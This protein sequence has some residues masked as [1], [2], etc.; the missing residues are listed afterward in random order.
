MPRHGLHLHTAPLPTRIKLA[1]SI[2]LWSQ[3]LTNASWF[4]CWTPRWSLLNVGPMNCR[5]LRACIPCSF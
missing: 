1:T 5:Q 4:T 3:I 2:C